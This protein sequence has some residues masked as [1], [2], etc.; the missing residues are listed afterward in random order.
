MMSLFVAV[1]V[2]FAT[3]ADADASERSAQWWLSRVPCKV[4]R[5]Y[6][7]KYDVATAESWARNKGATEVQIEDARRCL[8]GHIEASAKK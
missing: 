7:A 4:V 8:G 1:L 3:T 6:V 2:L 5:Y